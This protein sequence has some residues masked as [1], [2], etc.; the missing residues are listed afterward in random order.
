DR[1][2]SVAL[3]PELD[4][5]GGAE[6]RD[7]ERGR[8]ADPGDQGADHRLPERRGVDDGAHQ[9]TG[10]GARSWARRMKIAVVIASPISETMT[11]P[12]APVPNRRVTPYVAA[13]MAAEA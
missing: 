5:T 7:G 10:A 6:D 12:A 9:P 11:G 8:H 2:G 3:A 4:R 13:P 1:T